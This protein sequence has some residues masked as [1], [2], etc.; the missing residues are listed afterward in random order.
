VNET[1][2]ELVVAWRNAAER[3]RK[4]AARLDSP[5]DRSRNDDVLLAEAREAARV[6]AGCADQLAAAL[7]QSLDSLQ[8]KAT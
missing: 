4:D 6:L 7:R 2:T 3:R 5:W 8:R 1:L